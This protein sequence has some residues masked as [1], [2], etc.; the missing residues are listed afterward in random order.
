MISKVTFLKDKRPSWWY[1]R[2]YSL[3]GVRADVSWSISTCFGI[4]ID[5]LSKKSVIFSTLADDS[6]CSHD[7]RTY[8][9]LKASVCIR[10]LVLACL[11]IVCM[12]FI[13]ELLDRI[14]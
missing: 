3:R 8:D 1:Q 7:R 13:P 5:Y 9:E 4:G 14:L 2:K 10:E 11:H 12:H 6:V